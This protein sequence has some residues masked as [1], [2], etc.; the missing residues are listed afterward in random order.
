MNK[1]TLFLYL[2]AFCFGILLLILIS[3]TNKGTFYQTTFPAS[4]LP[5][6]KWN[7][8]NLPE[9]KA[10]QLTCTLPE[11]LI[12]IEWLGFFSIH[13][14][15]FVSIEDHLIYSYQAE[16]KMMLFGQT[17]GNIWNFIPILEEYASQTIQ[18]RL[19]SPY[20]ESMLYQISIW[21]IKWMF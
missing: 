20:Q 12:G 5:L 8:T 21:A 17:P 2:S 14:N 4:V 7:I 13:Q 11:E 10:I 15:I 3:I 18:V 16:P 19:T 1:K 6:T 9:E